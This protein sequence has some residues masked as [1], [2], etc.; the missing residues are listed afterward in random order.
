MFLSNVT[1]SRIGIMNFESPI[2]RRS[3]DLV[4][5]KNPHLDRVTCEGY[6]DNRF[7][8]IIHLFT[9]TYIHTDPRRKL[10]SIIMSSAVKREDDI[11]SVILAV[12]QTA[13]CMIDGYKVSPDQQRR[14]LAACDKL[15]SQLKSSSKRIAKLDFQVSIIV[16]GNQWNPSFMHTDDILIVD[17]NDRHQ[18]CSRHGNIPDG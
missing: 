13:E 15:S 18:N 7:L 14:L 12:S 6:A 2:N 16:Q 17:G 10:H 1:P 3:L 4:R 9:T 11:E 8:V 5:Y